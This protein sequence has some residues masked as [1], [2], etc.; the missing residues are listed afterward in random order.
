MEILNI[1]YALTQTV[2]PLQIYLIDCALKQKKEKKNNL[3]FTLAEYPD[4]FDNTPSSTPALIPD[5][6]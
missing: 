6:S 5:S 2:S 1:L 4:A 3:I